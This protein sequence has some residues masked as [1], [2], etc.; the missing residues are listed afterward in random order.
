M[1][2]RLSIE[3][4]YPKH[5]A[6][7]RLRWLQYFQVAK[8]I[9]VFYIYAYAKM[10]FYVSTRFYSPFIDNQYVSCFQ[11]HLFVRNMQPKKIQILLSVLSTAGSYV[12]HSPLI[13]TICSLRFILNR[14]YNNLCESLVLAHRSTGQTNLWSNTRIQ[15][16]WNKYWL[17]Y[18]EVLRENMA[19]DH[20]CWWKNKYY[21]SIMIFFSTWISITFLAINEFI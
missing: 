6:E 20:L 18:S 14:N 17:H 12:K 4:F 5:V 3:P 9:I 11:N 19:I 21:V 2:N 13:V 1:I 7:R 16:N 10:Q 15:L 8:E